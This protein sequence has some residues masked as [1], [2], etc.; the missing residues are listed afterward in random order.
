ME[1]EYDKALEVLSDAQFRSFQ[2]DRLQIS[3]EARKRLAA[4]QR[5]AEAR[6]TAASEARRAEEAS[7]A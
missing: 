2:A 4:R 7:H 1:T 3:G 6:F 5:D